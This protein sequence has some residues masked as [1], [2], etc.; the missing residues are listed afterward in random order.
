LSELPLSIIT[1]THNHANYIGQCLDALVPEVSHIGGE[2]IVVDNV[3]DDESAAIRSLAEVLAS[4][5]AAHVHSASAAG[6]IGS[7]KSET[8]SRSRF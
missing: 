7:T 3:S 2:I 5:L 4:T 1:V 8:E 6:A